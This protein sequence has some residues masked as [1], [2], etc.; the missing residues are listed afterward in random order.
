MMNRRDI[1][2]IRR[3]EKTI[4][5]IDGDIHVQIAFKRLRLRKDDWLITQA[6]DFNS[7]VEE[8]YTQLAAFRYETDTCLLGGG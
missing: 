8:I 1:K 5:G 4:E 7:K 2:L 6:I 3:K